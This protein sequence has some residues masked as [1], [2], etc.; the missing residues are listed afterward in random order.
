MNIFIGIHRNLGTHISKV[1]SLTLDEWPPSHIA[2]MLSVGNAL[3]NS[4]WEFNTRGQAKP[5]SYTH[6]SP[7]RASL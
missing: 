4:V 3:A 5:G 6:R 1:R 2:V 7:F